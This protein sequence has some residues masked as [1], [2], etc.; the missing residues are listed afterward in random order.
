MITFMV[1]VASATGPE[2]QPP[3]VKFMV[4]R[5]HAEERRPKITGVE[6]AFGGADQRAAC[7][8]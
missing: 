6:H 4:E 2:R 7:L 5:G 8:S 3:P 1:R